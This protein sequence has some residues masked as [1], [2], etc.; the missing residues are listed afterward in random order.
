MDN[1]QIIHAKTDIGV[2]TTWQT[3]EVERLLTRRNSIFFSA[4]HLVFYTI[5]KIIIDSSNPPLPLHVNKFSVL[6]GCHSCDVRFTQHN[7]HVRF[8]TH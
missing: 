2:I 7:T 3:M 5:L 8:S 1:P 4:R 6:H